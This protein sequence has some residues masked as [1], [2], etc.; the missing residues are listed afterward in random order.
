MR[1]STIYAGSGTTDSEAN[2]TSAAIAAEGEGLSVFVRP[3]IDFL[4]PQASPSDPN[5][6]YVPGFY[7][8]DNVP[9]GV[10]PATVPNDNDGTDNYRGFLN[11][12][13]LDLPKFFGSPSQIGSY[14]YMI[15]SEAAAA[16]AAGATMFRSAPSST[17]WPTT[18]IPPWK[19][20][21]PI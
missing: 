9:A 21:G 14:D 17:R 18:P 15:V 6:Y 20:A 8:P 2:L 10:T 13:D 4:Y 1:I 5:F 7:S 3:L 16:Q 12:A 19:K 11:P